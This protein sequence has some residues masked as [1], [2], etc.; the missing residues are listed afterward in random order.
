MMLLK[1]TCLRFPITLWYCIT[2]FIVFISCNHQESKPTNNKIVKQV[3]SISNKKDTLLPP[4]VV[5]LTASN[6]PKI[7]KAGKPTVVIDTASIGAPFFTNYT[8][9]DG[10]PINF[11]TNCMQDKEGNL[12]IGTGGGGL[13]KYN[14]KNFIT[15][16]TAQGLSNNFI[17]YIMQDKAGNIWIGTI[18]NGVSKYDGKTFTNYSVTEG[19]AGNLVMGMAQDDNGNICL[20]QLTEKI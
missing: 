1:Q 18:S 7:I 2:M 5:L 11:I 3:P 19:L 6:Q 12:W 17:E 4:K 13:V 15:Y 10:L 9:D 8:I 14:G 16:T 20:S